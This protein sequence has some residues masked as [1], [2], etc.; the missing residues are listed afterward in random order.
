MFKGNIVTATTVTAGTNIP[1][2]VDW[3]TNNNTRYDITTNAI[4]FLNGGKYNVNVLLNLTGTA[5]T[6]ISAQLYANGVAIPETLAG[7]ELTA[8]TGILALT[9][10]DTI[11]VA[12]ILNNQLANIS[13]R[14][15]GNATVS[16]GLITV[17]KVR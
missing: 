2:V 8:S 13:V 3:N 15:N 7:A 1:F 17:E 10:V 4:E 9:I 14:L 16:N 6:T 12:N 11:N 5:G